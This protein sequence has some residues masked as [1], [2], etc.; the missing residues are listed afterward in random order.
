ML[1][2]V[3]W[4]FWD[5]FGATF[6]LSPQWHD[7]F[8]TLWALRTWPSATTWWARPSRRSQLLRDLRW[9][10]TCN[11]T[12]YSDWHD[13]QYKVIWCNLY[14]II[15]IWYDICH[16]VFVH[17]TCHVAHSSDLLAAGDWSGR[18]HGLSRN[19]RSPRPCVS[20][21]DAGCRATAMGQDEKTLKKNKKVK[22]YLLMRIFLW[23]FVS[24]SSNFPW[25]DPDLLVR[26][27]CCSIL[28]VRLVSWSIGWF[29]VRN[30]HYWNRR[31]CYRDFCH[32]MSSAYSQLDSCWKLGRFAWMIAPND[33]KAA[34]SLMVEGMP[35]FSALAM[36]MSKGLVVSCVY[37]MRI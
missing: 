10:L 4:R 29:M 30:G 2:H 9:N 26:F 36:A 14:M 18:D 34:D 17:H 33:C 32:N 16:G 37:M 27:P 7:G 23:L 28:A 20:R 15:S 21:G 19:G 25:K 12:L 5:V 24:F 1:C 35:L 31:R 22:Q 8:V 3:S 6:L 13:W 11:H